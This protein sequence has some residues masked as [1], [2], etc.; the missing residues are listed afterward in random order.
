MMWHTAIDP[1]R[2]ALRGETVMPCHR[3]PA[4]AGNSRVYL[5]IRRE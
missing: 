5:R 1:Q 2:Q 3:R 4:E